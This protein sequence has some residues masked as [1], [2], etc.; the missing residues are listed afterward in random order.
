MIMT[1]ASCD[2][3]NSSRKWENDA[4]KKKRNTCTHKELKPEKL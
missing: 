1:Q 4:V 3:E 2:A